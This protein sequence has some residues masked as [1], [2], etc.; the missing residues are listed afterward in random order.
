MKS[1]TRFWKLHFL[2]DE[3]S[4]DLPRRAPG[5]DITCSKLEDTPSHSMEADLLILDHDPGDPLLQDWLESFREHQAQSLILLADR[6]QGDRDWYRAAVPL[7]VDNLLLLPMEKN[8]W[9][10][11]LK[12][13]GESLEAGGEF[14]R[15]RSRMEKT[16]QELLEN[17]ER[18]SSYLAE[19]GQELDDL[20]R[21]LTRRIS[22]L[23]TL[24]QLGLDLSS[25]S[26]WDHALEHFLATSV[27]TLKFSG[28]SL[29]LWSFEGRRLSSRASLHLDEDQLE[30]AIA[31]I[32]D[33]GPKERLGMGIA[34]LVD[35]NILTERE[36][37][38]RE[39]PWDLTVIP[40]VHG[41]D[42]QGYLIYRKHYAREKA[43]DQDFH[44]LKTVQTILSEELAHA[45]A[46][47]KLKKL[48]EFNRTVL[49]SIRAAVIAVD[50]FGTINYRNPSVMELFGERLPL[51][52][53]F[54]FG[55]S[56]LAGD[57]GEMELGEDDWIQREIQFYEDE[58]VP[59]RE[60][61]VSSTRLFQRHPQE[62]EFVLVFEDMTI[63][64]RLA[65]ELRRAE[66]LTG[67][68]ELSAG[69]AH[70]IRNPLAGIS[71]ITQLL[72]DKLGDEDKDLKGYV[73][74]ILGETERLNRIVQ[75]LLEF[76]RP[77]EPMMTVFNLYEEMGSVLDLV[78]SMAEKK[79][80]SLE[81]PEDGQE[82]KVWADRGQLQQV[83]LNLLRNA[84]EAC[85]EG[86]RVGLRLE[87]GTVGRGRMRV[88]AT[89]WDTGPG[90]PPEFE[91]RL[92]NPF[93]TTKV[94]GTG[95]GLAIC[96]KIVQEHGGSIRYQSGSGGGS[97]FIID[98]QPAPT[99]NK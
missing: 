26:N 5:W 76:S 96:L 11:L 48:G 50:G 34:A 49:D 60:L 24:Y 61:L 90:V 1:R 70:E 89:V 93:F 13:L 10:E 68:G 40:L 38:T 92:F 86:Q 98:L 9:E 83:F 47:H 27:N 32:K 12:D 28:V 2:S 67:L 95:L 71:M 53:P 57:G 88:L 99:R 63:Y 77:S 14:E 16:G 84:V 81:L 29:L 69:V 59:P 75:S 33:L 58:E 72:G 56:F 73:D 87:R 6:G 79:K 25:Q 91:E 78:R 39:Q 19:P 20:H 42:A 52:G 35:G 7:P 74:R 30:E 31:T 82:I 36:L 80:V 45:K 94:E 51:G 64:Q 65:T 21:Q 17:R 43:F 18:L 97:E 3:L 54:R 22:Q 41:E 55:D 15:L 4:S 44:F 85:D 62:V 8:N 23:S 37:E 66:R 46:I